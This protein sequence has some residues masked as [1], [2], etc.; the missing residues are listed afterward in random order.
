[1]ISRGRGKANPTLPTLTE[2]E[3]SRQALSLGFIKKG[4]SVTNISLKRMPD[5]AKKLSKRV[6]VGRAFSL[7]QAQVGYEKRKRTKRG[8]GLGLKR[9]KFELGR[10]TVYGEFGKKLR[11]G[12]Q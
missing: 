2:M 12:R 10:D 11:P 3:M 5:F 1:M 8:L 9:Q 6:G 7:F 4:Q